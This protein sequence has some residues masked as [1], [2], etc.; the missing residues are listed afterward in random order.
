MPRPFTAVESTAI[1]SRLLEVAG[2]SFAR[3][4]LRAT[5]VESLARAA[6]I[7]KGA[8][9]GFF[10]SKEQL[11]LALVDEYERRMHAEVVA[12]V[13]A[14]PHRG[15]EVLLAMALSATQDDPLMAVVM[16]DE[17]AAVLRSMDP[18]QREALLRRDE[19]LVDTVVVVLGDAGVQLSVPPG[20]LVG[21]LRSLVFVGWHRED[22]GPDLVDEV[23]AWLTPAL[24]SALLTEAAGR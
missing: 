5:S 8:F 24:R 16:S 9:Y 21:L 17:G 3:R 6:G 11:F 13:Q 12:A 20:L 18:Q 7:S 1:R 22:I 14:D 10:A 4:G 23:A 19:V 2:E 15:V